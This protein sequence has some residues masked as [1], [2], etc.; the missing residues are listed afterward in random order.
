VNFIDHK[1]KNCI[2]VSRDRE[3]YKAS[4]QVYTGPSGL[5]YLRNPNR[6]ALGEDLHTIHL[7]VLLEVTADKQPVTSAIFQ[8]WSVAA[9]YWA[10]SKNLKF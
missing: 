3:S 10:M 2:I 4:G 9:C 5:R 1:H 6:K 8:Q 7:P